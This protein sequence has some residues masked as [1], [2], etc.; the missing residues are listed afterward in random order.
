[1]E[2]N[3]RK[4]YLPQG[5]IINTI[6]FGGGTPSLLSGGETNAII[7]SIAAQFDLSKTP[8]I[9]LETNPDDLTKEKLR[10]LRS[11]PVNR[12]SIGVQSFS[13]SDLKVMNRAHNASQALYSIK[14]SQDAGWENI[15][16]DLM[17][18]LP[19]QSLADWK[20]NLDTFFELGVPHLSAYCLTIEPKTALAHFVKK[21]IISTPNDIANAGQFELLMDET[22][23]AGLIHYEISNFCKEGFYSKHNTAY[24]KN[25]LYLGIGPSAHSYNGITRQWNVSNNPIYIKNVLRKENFFEQENLSNQTKFN[26]YILTSL[27][28]MW[29]IDLSVITSIFPEFETHLLQESQEYLHKGLILEKKNTLI[30]S[31]KGKLLADTIASDLFYV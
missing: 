30:L 20:K 17:Y 2:I 25:E 24:W 3:L 4:S 9:T 14:A 11:T 5:S 18:G 16:I 22:E 10:E 6:Y 26:E 15:T 8:E 28:T 21:G 23:K 7:D 31:R 29:G 19:N 12:F 27:R 13:D 1:M